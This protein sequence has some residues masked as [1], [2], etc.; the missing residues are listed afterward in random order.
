MRKQNLALSAPLGDKGG[1]ELTS[2]GADQADSLNTSTFKYL[3]SIIG[4][5]TGMISKNVP[6]YLPSTLVLV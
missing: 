6:F 4:S 5:K 2:G 3:S 1:E